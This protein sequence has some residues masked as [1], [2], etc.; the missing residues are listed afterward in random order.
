MKDKNLPDD[1]KNKSLLDLTRLAN[2]LTENLENKKDLKES[3][4]EY[5]KLISLNNFIQKKFQS[6]SREISSET[7]NKI[8]KILKDEK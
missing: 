4:R 3:F 1:I 5:Q 6:I 7:K 8:D 2:K